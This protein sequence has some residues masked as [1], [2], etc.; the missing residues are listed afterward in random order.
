M[1]PCLIVCP[2]FNSCMAGMMAYAARETGGYLLAENFLHE[3][4]R[5]I[6]EFDRKYT[7]RG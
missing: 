6:Y 4:N 7:M 5:A 1:S 3:S 2:S